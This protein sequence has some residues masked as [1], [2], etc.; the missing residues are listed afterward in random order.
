MEPVE[1]GPV[2]LSGPNKLKDFIERVGWTAIQ[3][4]LAFLVAVPI[5]KDGSLDWTAVNALLAVVLAVVYNAVVNAVLLWA[6]K[7]QSL[8]ADLLVRCVKTFVSAFA[9]VYTINGVDDLNWSS[10]GMAA[11][12]GAVAVLSVIKGFVADRVVD[13]TITPA[14]TAKVVP[15]AA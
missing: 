12:A 2:E 7:P 3:S 4:A 11:A 14:S 15:Q 1:P 13:N 8:W 5:F 9:A 10:L 6:P